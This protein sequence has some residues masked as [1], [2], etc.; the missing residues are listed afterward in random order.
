[1][2]DYMPG[3]QSIGSMHLRWLRE[4]TAKD[5]A[6]NHLAAVQRAEDLG[7][8]LGQG[9]VKLLVLVNGGAAAAAL[10]FVGSLATKD[11]GINLRDLIPLANT[12][13]WFAWGVGLAVCAFMMG[14]LASYFLIL[15]LS[16]FQHQEESPWIVETR[17]SRI[18]LGIALCSHT[19]A[20]LVA[21]CSLACFISGIF[22]IRD[23]IGD[24]ARIG[25]AVH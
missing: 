6:Q 10:A 22:A 3:S 15:N 14:H 9:G 18:W 16:Y 17:K 23:A 11:P 13:I 19:L 20:V 7:L 5:A 2:R 24:L 21:V 8:N 1:M 25:A 4:A 12:L